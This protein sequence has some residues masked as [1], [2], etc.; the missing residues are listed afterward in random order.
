MWYSFWCPAVTACTPGKE[1]SLE[2]VE[3]HCIQVLLGVNVGNEMNRM[4]RKA[5]KVP[6]MKQLSAMMLTCVYFFI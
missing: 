5:F 2:K 6:S 1:W 3:F 4:S